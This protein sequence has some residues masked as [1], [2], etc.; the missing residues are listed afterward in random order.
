MRKYNGK[1]LKA[2]QAI[3][4]DR[5]GASLTVDRKPGGYQIRR[6]ALLACGLL[7][8][9]TLCAFGYM[10]FSSLS[11][12]DAMFAAV[13]QGEGRFEVIVVNASDRELRLQDKVKLMQWSTGREV[14]GEPEKIRMETA[15][16]PPYSKGIVSIDLSEG[17]DISA[18][19]QKLPEGDSYYFVLTNNDFAFGQDWMCFFDFEAER[20]EDVESRLAEAAKQRTE[21][22]KAERERKRQ[23]ADSR[24]SVTD[25]LTCPDWIWPTVSRDISGSYGKQ[26]NGTCSDHINIAGTDGDEIYAVADGVVTEAAFESVCGNFI[27]VDLGDGVAVRYGHLKDVKV[28]AGDAVRQGQVIATMGKTGMAMDSNLLFAVTVN[29]EAINP[30]AAE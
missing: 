11:G 12:D 19:E 26:N 4:Q 2:I 1:H 24:Q 8:F 21:R 15:A 20:T 6:A 10:K 14:E 7:C 25:S 28:S 3:V 13:Y 22:Q 23:E 27:V 30:L 5:T 18:L 29:G 9:V 16:I 17:Y